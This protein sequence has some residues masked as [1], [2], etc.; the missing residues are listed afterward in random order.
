MTETKNP[1][2]KKLSVSPAKTLTLKRGVEQGTVRQSFSHGRT[3]QVVV[4]K[5]KR[6]IIATEGKPADAAS[7]EVAPKKRATARASEKTAPIP[8][9]SPAPGAASPKPSGVVL[10]TLTEEERSARAHA[11]RRCPRARGRRT[12][13]RRGR[14]P[15]PRQPRSGRQGRPRSGGD[16]QAGG[17]RSSPARGRSQA[18]GRAGGQEAFRRGYDARQTG[19]APGARSRGRR[20]PAHDTPRCRTGAP[21]ARSQARARRA[22]KAA[23]PSDARHRLACR[24]G[25]RAFG[26]FVPSPHASA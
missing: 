5:V 4:E 13:D 19:R 23:R 6:R 1:G 2:G 8:A 17:R 15:P 24:R 11:P 9:A 18:Q 10:R 7:V 26:C 20:R 22:A 25:T 3:K 14:S 16:A 12:Q 21:G